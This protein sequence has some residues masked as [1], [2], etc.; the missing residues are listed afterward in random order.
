MSLTV[1]IPAY[2]ERN[3]IAKALEPYRFLLKKH[4]D[5]EVVVVANGCSDGT[6]R[7]VEREFP[8]V[9]LVSL[10][11]GSKTAAINAGLEFA[12]FEHVLVQ[13]ADIVI[14]PLSLEI[15][16]SR[17]GAQSYLL[18]SPY[19]QVQLQEASW[20]VK[21][22]YRFWELTPIFQA[23]MTCSCCYILS[24]L[25]VRA[26]Y[27]LPEVIADDGYVKATLGPDNITIFND[28]YC[29]VSAPENLWSLIKI[30]SRARL[31]N[32][33]L[34][35]QNGMNP[36]SGKNSIKR[37]ALLMWEERAFISGA[38]YFAVVVA[39]SLRARWQNMVG[40]NR[41]ERDESSRKPVLTACDG[42]KSS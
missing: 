35:Q 37:L 20:A 11:Q 19:P 30:K 5:L 23:G 31:G 18:G 2:N 14:R 4:G 38:I 28:V 29:E 8:E 22:Y 3:V 42:E 7:F 25:A 16:I 6:E 39:C 34:R 33:Q 1:I 13:D 40:Q 21:A 10:T 12:S 24:P 9:R 32:R 15:L 26:V 27:P 36:S 17:T 41:W